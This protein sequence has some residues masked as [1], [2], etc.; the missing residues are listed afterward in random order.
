[1]THSDTGDR[2]LTVKSLCDFSLLSLISLIG[3]GLRLL[4][5]RPQQEAGVQILPLPRRSVHVANVTDYS[6]ADD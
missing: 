2:N 3:R 1:M 6:N 5:Y 4:L